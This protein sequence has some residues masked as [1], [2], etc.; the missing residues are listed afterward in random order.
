[1]RTFIITQSEADL[2][3]NAGLALVGRALQHDTELGAAVDGDVGLRHGIAHSDGLASYIG[4]VCLGKSDFEAIHD[5]RSE[6]FFADALG[7]E[8]VPS[9][10]T[11]RQRFD[12]RAGDDL[13]YVREAAL[14]FL[15]NV[16]GDPGTLETGHVPLDADVTPFDNAGSRTVGVS[17]TYKGH[18]GYAPMAAYLGREGYCL[19][20]E[21]REASQHCQNATPALLERALG[22]ARRVSQ[23]PILVRLDGGY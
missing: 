3:S 6:P 5:Q 17:R 20:L 18:H 2:T 19:E 10:A 23:A 21:L 13:G 11:L 7:L 12:Q 15:V 4:L 8:S 14:D 1:M 16:G 9:E 22:Q